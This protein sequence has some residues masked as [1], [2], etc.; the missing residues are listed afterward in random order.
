MDTK[1][2]NEFF[3]AKF[4]DDSIKATLYDDLINIECYDG[5]TTGIFLTKGDALKF[6]EVLT[7]LALSV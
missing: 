2:K 4:K 5:I 7:K 6:A 3:D 1:E